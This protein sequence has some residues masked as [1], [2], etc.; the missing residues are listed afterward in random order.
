MPGIVQVISTSIDELKNR[1][2]KCRFMGLNDIRE[3]KESSPYGLDSNPIA[4]MRAIYVETSTK[5]KYYVIGYVTTE[6]MADV[7]ETRLFS[8]DTNGQLQAYM[9]LKNEGNILELNGNDDNAVLFNKLK[10]EFN[11]LKQSHNDL[12]SKVNANAA[13]QGTHTHPYLNATTPS[14]TSPSG[15]PGQ[16]STPSDANI[17]N[18]KNEKIKTNS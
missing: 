1:L 15:V 8:T 18:A 14:V 2:V 10:I 16:T 17:D 12:V 9:W 4:D 3:P 5:G 13:L 6:R 7:G 11:E